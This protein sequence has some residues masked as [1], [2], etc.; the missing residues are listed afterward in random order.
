MAG[1]RNH[2]ALLHSYLDDGAAM[3][4]PHYGAYLGW[5][6]LEL[7]VIETLCGVRLA[8]SFGGLVDTPMHRAVVALALDDIHDR[9]SIGSMVYGNTVDMV[10]DNNERNRA[11]GA[12]CAL[13]DIATQLHRP[14]G[15]AIHMT[16]STSVTRRP[17]CSRCAESGRASLTAGST[18]YRRRRSA[19]SSPGKHD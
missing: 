6:A 7:H 19:S 8:H 18:S 3:Q 1:M 10:V 14:T 12:A 16:A 11:V 9:R 15:H 17:C 5:A 2:G 13:V 4:L